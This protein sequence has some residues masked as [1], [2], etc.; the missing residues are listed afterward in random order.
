MGHEEARRLARKHLV[1]RWEYIG[2]MGWQDRLD[3]RLYLSRN[4]ASA[5]RNIAAG[6]VPDGRGNYLPIVG[7]VV[8]DA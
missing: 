1:E 4:L 5:T 7:A 3:R 6:R 8:S 2:R